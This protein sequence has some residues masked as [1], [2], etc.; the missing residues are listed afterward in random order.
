MSE[1]DY[2]LKYAEDLYLHDPMF[3]T[4]VDVIAD[5]I[6]KAQLT[7][8]EVRQAA[9]LASIRVEQH[10]VKPMYDVGLPQSQDKE[11]ER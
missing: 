2:G 8:A 5:V 11:V 3:R 9:T 6:C 10:R 7:P 4:L 1:N